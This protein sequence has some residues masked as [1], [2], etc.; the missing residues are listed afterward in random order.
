MLIQH[1]EPGELEELVLEELSFC[2]EEIEKLE[3]LLID[4]LVPKDKA[5]QHSAVLEL[6]AGMCVK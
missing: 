6:R 1:G 5:D 3:A 2:R 4:A